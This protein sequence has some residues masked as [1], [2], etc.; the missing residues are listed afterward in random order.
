MKKPH[1]RGYALVLCM[2]FSVVIVSLTSSLLLSVGRDNAEGRN[3]EN[4]VRALYASE[5]AV[6]NGIETIR[7]RLL[8]NPQPDITNMVAPALPNVSYD[9]YEVTYV[10]GNFNTLAAAQTTTGVIVGGVNNGLFAQQTPIQVMATASV[11]GAKATVADAVRIDLIPVFQFAFFFDGDFELMQTAPININGRIHSNGN[12]HFA[13]SGTWDGTAT[14]VNINGVV[15]AAGHINRCS[16]HN[17]TT[18]TDA[19]TTSAVKIWA[20][21]SSNTAT[22]SAWPSLSFGFDTK[23]TDNSAQ[24]LAQATSLS[25]TFSTQALDHSG[26]Q[27]ALNIPVRVT[28]ASPLRFSRPD[29]CTNGS[30][31]A[32]FT[33]G[34]AVGIIKRPTGGYSTPYPAAAPP[35]AWTA[36]Y[37]PEVGNPPTANGLGPCDAGTGY[38]HA[39]CEK[40]TNSVP[41]VQIDKTSD[42]A[43]VVDERLYWK[44]DI[45][46][47][48]GIWYTQDSNTPVFDPE[49]WDMRA[50]PLLN[51][52]V[53][54]GYLFARVLRYSW[55]WDARESRVFGSG[56][57]YQR[58]QQ[59]R[60]T[61]FDVEAFNALLSDAS[62]RTL[63]FPS[64]IPTS[65]IIIYISETYNP[66]FD[67]ARATS[68]TNST[69][70]TANVRNF[71]DFY[72]MD[73]GI[74]T[75][76]GSEGGMDALGALGAKLSPSRNS[77]RTPAALGWSPARLWGSQAGIGAGLSALTPSPNAA[78]FA[79]IK[80][81]VDT[82]S[83]AA[84]FGNQWTGA[85][86]AS[87]NPSQLT[88][89]CQEPLLL[90][91]PSYTGTVPT[92][93]PCI[94]SGATPWG[95]ENAIRIVRAQNA[96]CNGTCPTSAVTSTSPVAGSGLTI[97]TDNRLYVLGDV[98]VKPL[99]ASTA[100]QRFPGKVSFIADSI[101]LL[102]QGFSDRV[103]QRGGQDGADKLE[104]SPRLS[105]STGQIAA[106][107][108]KTYTNEQASGTTPTT[109]IGQMPNMCTPMRN[110][111]IGRVPRL[112]LL[113]YV[114]ASLLMGDVPS[115]KVGNG[116]DD[117]DSSGG[118]NNFPRFLETWRIGSA[119]GTDSNILGSQV[120][121]FRA[122]QGN[123]RFR[124]ADQGDPDRASWMKARAADGYDLPPAAS[125]AYPCVYRPPT[126]KWS[127]DTALNANPANLPPGTPRVFATERLRWV[128]R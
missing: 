57:K 124:S 15:T 92:T 30:T 44:A 27:T 122:E 79:D 105:H 55:F 110:N 102:S 51:A 18:C 113:D 74:E 106:M 97:A 26:G 34:P 14:F 2:V 72:V 43:G 112:A 36:T 65:G 115:C 114:N 126:R 104:V 59:I 93:P 123:S 111:N 37:G 6:A 42:D 84:R 118:A 70:A 80:A 71:L 67:D 91:A 90:S 117:G 23:T 12:A 28:G 53:T 4:M 1:P 17:S 86:P 96:G 82:T 64:G 73:D 38:A 78:F 120:S 25:S 50:L 21:N 54:Q 29:V 35:N 87:T 56:T 116:A 16:I 61:D 52:K 99:T 60:T 100:T 63:L 98:N 125:P 83:G 13:R 22:P 69:V 3:Q 32:S 24:E 81:D 75:A 31:P 33:Q 68:A 49:N 20:G 109:D 128:R 101:T 39:R 107:A 121:L 76:Y 19:T 10:D 66:T 119:T 46:I 11:G 77:G 41:L 95:P 45:R 40:L 103:H 8:D 5:A 7:L 94:Q 62:A 48:D 58:G 88:W 108:F 127:F 9:L 89:A 85:L 47:I